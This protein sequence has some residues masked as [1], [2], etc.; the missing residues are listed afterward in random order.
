[1]I[2][3]SNL[4]QVIF[5]KDE[6]F[7]I[8]YDIVDDVDGSVQAIPIADYFNKKDG[9]QKLIKNSDATVKIEDGV[10]LRH[11]I[12]HLTKINHLLIDAFDIDYLDFHKNILKMNGQDINKNRTLTFK[13]KPFKNIIGQYS[14]RFNFGDFDGNDF[15]GICYSNIKQEI[16]SFIKIEEN[17]VFEG[18]QFR[19]KLNFIDLLKFINHSVFGNLRN[20]SEYENDSNLFDI[21]LNNIEVIK[22]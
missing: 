13:C 3:L 19:A 15:F 8:D 2:V 1:M 6:A 7:I 21:I 16:N 18:K 9:L 4:N 17:G 12:H 14:I 10:R 22:D 20:F 5:E 11:I